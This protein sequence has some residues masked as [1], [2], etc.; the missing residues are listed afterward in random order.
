MLCLVTSFT[1][2]LG[3]P[4]CYRLPFLCPSYHMAFAANHFPA[5]F[6]FRLISPPRVLPRVRS[7]LSIIHCDY[8]S[9]SLERSL[10]I[11]T[12]V[13]ALRLSGK[14]AT[15]TGASSGLGRAIA[16]AYAEHGTRL[17]C[18]RRSFS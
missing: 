6:T 15:V 5:P 8:F 11:I 14:V 18:V 3:L 1:P 7:P 9:S 2:D 10:S 12:A 17:V 4:F 16:L 13:S